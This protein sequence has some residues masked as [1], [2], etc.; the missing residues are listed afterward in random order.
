[1]VKTLAT[2]LFASLWLAAGCTSEH[3]QTM[4]NFQNMHE[5]VRADAKNPQPPGKWVMNPDTK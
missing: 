4:Q 3:D 2:I 5:K 1:M